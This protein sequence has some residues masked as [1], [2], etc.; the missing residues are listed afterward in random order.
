MK[1]LLSWTI[2]SNGAII[3]VME[4]NHSKKET[5]LE[6]IALHLTN[7]IGSPISIIVH[8]FF[9][10][11]IF[12]LELFGFSFDKIMLILTTVV[13]LEAIYLAIFIQM[14][15]NRHAQELSEIS[16]DVEDISEDVEEISKDIDDIQEDVEDLGEEMEKDDKE[17]KIKRQHNQDKILHIESIL[18]E[19]LLEVR[20][21]KDKK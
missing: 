15:V 9:F 12:S 3:L 13:S 18:K 20:E 2:K 4:N 6:K 1:E 14:T 19:L 11:G 8:S 5:R 16:E 17:T 7:S 10:V 21:L